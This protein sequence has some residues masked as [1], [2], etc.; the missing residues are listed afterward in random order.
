MKKKK[1]TKYNV[2]DKLRCKNNNGFL[3][4][5]LVCFICFYTF[6]K[7]HKIS[8]QPMIYFYPQDIKARTD[9]AIHMGKQLILLML[10][11]INNKSSEL[12]KTCHLQ[13][14]HLII[15]YIFFLPIRD[16]HYQNF[17]MKIFVHKKVR[18][19]N[20]DKISIYKN[21]N[22]SQYFISFS[23]WHPNVTQM[24]RPFSFLWSWTFS[25]YFFHKQ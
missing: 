8:S 6:Y 10:T 22:K 5:T 1:P 23:Q 19:R 3:P 9:Q 20:K 11:H 7:F 15:N 18:C 2:E 14:N 17:L 21:R 4:W 24:N 16:C 13:H 12:I 25:I